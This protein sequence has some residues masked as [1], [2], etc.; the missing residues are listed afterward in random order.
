MQEN[1]QAFLLDG[2]CTFIWKQLLYVMHS[3]KPHFLM[4]LDGLCTFIWK[5]LLY[6]MHSSKPHFLM[7]G[8]NEG[9]TIFIFFRIR[10]CSNN[11][12]LV[13]LIIRRSSLACS[14]R[15]FADISIVYETPSP[16]L[17]ILS[18]CEY[19]PACL[20]PIP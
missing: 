18:V 9:R 4:G 8:W 13:H 5:Q 3:S 19:V 17:A 12:F 16:K 6:V 11:I 15:L 7:G 10:S 20:L 14:S 1:L 2:L